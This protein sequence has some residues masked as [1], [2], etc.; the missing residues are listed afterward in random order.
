MILDD[1]G[2][3]TLLIHLGM[4]AE[5]DLSVVGN[6]TNDEEEALFAA[7]KKRVAAKPGW[8]TQLG[9]AIRGV[10]EET[11]TGVHSL[12]KMQQA[13]T[14]LFP[15]INVNDSVTTTKFD[16]KYSSRE[17]LVNPICSDTHT[18]STVTN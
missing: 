1:G 8:Y 12:N 18:R 2:D 3:A 17:R 16:N 6:P 10:T 13:D 11:T 9:K 5:K 15:R 7:I 14:L 4:K